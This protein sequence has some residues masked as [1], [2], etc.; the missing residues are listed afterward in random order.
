MPGTH[1]AVLLTERELAALADGVVDALADRLAHQAFQPLPAAPDDDPEAAAPETSA[2]A[3]LH[4]LAHLQRAVARQTDRAAAEAAR[5][6]AGYPQLGKACSISRQGA[7]RRWPG[8]VPP[9]HH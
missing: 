5:A 2:L 4:A 6:G 9:A 3:R 1:F 8:L 7:R